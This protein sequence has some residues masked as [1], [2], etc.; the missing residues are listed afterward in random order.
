MYLLNI[1]ENILSVICWLGILQGILLAA[2]IYFHPKGDKSVNI[3]LALFI[4]AT[5]AV[6]TMPFIIRAVG[7]QH[8]FFIQ[9]LPLAGGPLLYLYLRSFKEAITW[10]K[11]Y[12]HFIPFVLYIFIAYWNLSVFGPKYPDAKDIP[13]QVLLS[14]STLAIMY[15][16]MVL[17]ILYYFKARKVLLS[18]QRSIQ[19]LF[20]ETSRIDLHWAK[21]LV[22]G[23]IV[24]V[25]SF[26]V[27]SPLA[28]RFPEHIMTFLTI[29]LTLGTP[30]IYIASVKGFLQNTIWQIKPDIDKLTVQSEMN[31]VEE[32]AFG[33]HEP[34]KQKKEKSIL[35]GDKM[36]GIVQKIVA[37]MEK[38]KLFQ[39]PELTLQ[40][41]ADKLEV[42]TYVVSA[43]LN[44]GLE[45]NFYDV[46]NGYRVEEAKH[47]LVDSKNRNYTI[48]SVGF[49]AGFNSKT[50]FNTVFKKFTG[51]TPTEFR[52]RQKQVMSHPI[53][54]VP[55]I[56]VS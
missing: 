42:P 19:H 29:I 2:I 17:Q 36:E 53:S 18:Y 39:E 38:E 51:L 50:T 34:L 23:Y 9:S 54:P 28:L 41:L 27:V 32:L 10:R 21:F 30:Y 15:S 26:V 56:A 43:A 11:V 48:L 45:K 5:S 40:Q 7:W 1:S 44:D 13:R 47:L 14:P 16:R 31:E 24:L 20:S 8:S 52:D 35:V 37:L 25:L 46:V 33:A 55:L 3:F 12:P 4:L 22:N 6:M 49:E